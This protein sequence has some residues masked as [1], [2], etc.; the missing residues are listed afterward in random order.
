[1]DQLQ[2]HDVPYGNNWDSVEEVAAWAEHADRVRPWREQIREHIASQIAALPPGARI[3]E[4][5]SG[6]GLLAHRVLERCSTLESY[7]LLDFSEPMLALSRRRLAKFPAATFVL[8]SFKS[9]D[10]PHHVGG[11]FDCVVSMQAVHELRHKRHARRLYEQGYGIL[12]VP[13]GIMIC[14]HT[15]FDDSP[16]STALY[17]T[18]EEQQEALVQAG[19][20]N[21][22]V[23]LT[24]DSLVLYAGE[25]TIRT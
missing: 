24:S 13:G 20:A 17:M 22:H 9:D 15:P 16:K 10:W 23:E 11:P 19:F 7:V 8:E 14:D 12:R 21:V 6:P 5:G 2:R 4:L 3:L 25:R 18:T 1:M